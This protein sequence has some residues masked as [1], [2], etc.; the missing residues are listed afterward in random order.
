MATGKA[1]STPDAEM[2]LC[3]VVLIDNIRSYLKNLC[4]DDRSILLIIEEHWLMES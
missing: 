4:V 2:K 3:K 1:C